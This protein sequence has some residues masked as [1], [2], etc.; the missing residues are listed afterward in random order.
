MYGIASVSQP[1]DY[2]SEKEKEKH[3]GSGGREEKGREENDDKGSTHA[4]RGKLGPSSLGHGFYFAED[5][6]LLPETSRGKWLFVDH[7]N[8]NDHSLLTHLSTV[9][10]CTAEGLV[11]N[12]CPSKIKKAQGKRYIL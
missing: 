12:C 4:R 7:H 5:L 1:S 11:R 3:G 8:Y 2:E 6:Q 9:G 10:R